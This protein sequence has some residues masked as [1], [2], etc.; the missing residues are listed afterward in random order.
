MNP[1]EAQMREERLKKADTPKIHMKIKR[2]ARGRAHSSLQEPITIANLKSSFRHIGHM[3]LGCV[4]LT[5]ILF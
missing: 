4:R 2:R 3:Y 5:P 1:A